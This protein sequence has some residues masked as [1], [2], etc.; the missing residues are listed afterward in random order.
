M[1]KVREPVQTAKDVVRILM[2]FVRNE[3]GDGAVRL[4]F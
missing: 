2:Q 1:F 3:P 4:D